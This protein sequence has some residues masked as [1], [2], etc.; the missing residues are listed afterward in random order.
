VQQSSGSEPHPEVRYD[1]GPEHELPTHTIPMRRTAPE[2]ASTD[3]RWWIGEGDERCPFCLQGYAIEV[4][5]RCVACDEP[6]CMH[7]VTIVRVSH[8]SRILCPDC[9]AEPEEKGGEPEDVKE[10][11]A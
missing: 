9:L 8:P 4:E 10:R 2:R 6:A 5:T 11:K 7:C 3:R 1:D